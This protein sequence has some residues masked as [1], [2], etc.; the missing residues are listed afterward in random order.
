MYMTIMS[1]KCRHAACTN[2]YQSLIHNLHQPPPTPSTRIFFNYPQPE[3]RSCTLTNRI[4]G[5]DLYRNLQPPEP[6]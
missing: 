2:R 5:S 3:I 1:A 6:T 4:T